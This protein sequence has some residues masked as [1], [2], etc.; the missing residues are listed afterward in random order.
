MVLSAMTRAGQ[1]VTPYRMLAQGM[2][3]HDAYSEIRE[4]QRDGEVYCCPHCFKA[5]GKRVALNFRGTSPENTR[6][7]FY[8][9]S[10]SKEKCA[11]YSG[12]SEAHITAKDYIAGWLQAKGAL[13]VYTEFHLDNL[14]GQVR[15]PDIV[16]VY[17]DRIEAHEVQISPITSTEI[18]QR[19]EDIIAQLRAQWPGYSAVVSWYFAPGNARK[20]EI[21]DYFLGAQDGVMGYRL[22]WTGE[23]KIPEWTWLLSATEIAEY[24]QTNK[25]DRHRP[26]ERQPRQTQSLTRVGDRVQI[27]GIEF[28]VT[29]V[30]YIQGR[31]LL[32]PTINGQIDYAHIGCWHPLVA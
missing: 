12:E 3:T 4:A 29:A 10:T 32:R 25:S 28:A 27:G 15:R 22:T 17:G 23:D 18:A 5:T 11:A 14:D 9:S 8:H 1:I 6:P 26:T 21:K 31:A 20:R 24:N 13:D 16:A 30:S 2:D 7:H 19:T